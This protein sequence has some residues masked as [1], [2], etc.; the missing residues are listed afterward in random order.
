MLYLFGRL[1]LSNSLYF[2]PDVRPDE[3]TEPLAARQLPEA[4][5]REALAT[6]RSP[7]PRQGQQVPL[8]SLPPAE[9]AS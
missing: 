6:G 4:P 3:H 7:Q 5:G 9:S 2:N 8:A 1:A